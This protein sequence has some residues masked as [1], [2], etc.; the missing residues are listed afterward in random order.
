MTTKRKCMR[1]R[2]EEFKNGFSGEGMDPDVVKF[3]QQAAVI[4]REK[5]LEATPAPPSAEDIIKELHRNK[6]NS[7]RRRDD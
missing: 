1:E 6:G 3:R 2:L 7:G 4:K 5:E